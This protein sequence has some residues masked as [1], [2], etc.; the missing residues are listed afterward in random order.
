VRDW[1][2]RALLITAV[3]EPRPASFRVFDR[4]AGVP[5]VRAVAASCAV[6]GVWPP[7]TIDGRRNMDGGIR[8]AANADLAAGC[9][10][11]G[12]ARP[13]A[14]GIGPMTSATSQVRGAPGA[15]PRGTGH[16]PTAPRRAPSGRNV[17]DPDKRA[18]APA[19][20][21]PRPPPSS[22]RIRS[23]WCD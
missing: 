9:E 2:D 8:S 14:R 20:G 13:I 12:R 10:R 11:G 23:V 16:H 21:W 3:D 17:L 19:P 15:V 18:A 4:A 5:L 6:P 7:V 1:P 22:D